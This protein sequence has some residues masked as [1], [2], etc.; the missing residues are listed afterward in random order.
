ML[1][2]C[3]FGDARKIS[4]PKKP[5]LVVRRAQLMLRH[6]N[7]V[8]PQ[9]MAH[10][11]L[12][13]RRRR[14]RR[15]CRAATI[16]ILPDGPANPIL[17]PTLLDWLGSDWRALAASACRPR[18][19]CRQGP[20]AK[21]NPGP[22]PPPTVLLLIGKDGA[23]RSRPYRRGVGRDRRADGGFPPALGLGPC[24][25]SAHVGGRPASGETA[26][27]PSARAPRSETQVADLL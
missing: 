7:L 6:G 27:G 5:S 23:A 25:L 2:P 1:P 22:T 16:P 19:A 8:A 4:P 14:A 18:S 24:Q 20:K 13:K 11:Q 12:R 10:D 21:G 26:Q 17:P 3:R 9:T 15:A